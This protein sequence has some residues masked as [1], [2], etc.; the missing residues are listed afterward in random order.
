M[1]IGVIYPLFHRNLR[2]MCQDGVVMY[3]NVG[4]SATYGL[5]PSSVLWLSR[6]HALK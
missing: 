6:N 4:S 3:V 5:V 2:Y 1:S